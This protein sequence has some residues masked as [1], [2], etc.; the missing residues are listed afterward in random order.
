ME[1]PRRQADGWWRGAPR[2]LWYTLRRR[3]RILGLRRL[4]VHAGFSE[5]NAEIARDVPSECA[6]AARAVSLTARH[7]Q[8]V[9][10]ELILI[11]KSHGQPPGLGSLP[12]TVLT[13]AGQDATWMQ[14][15]AELA[16][17]S[18]AGTHIVAPRGGH[19]LQH[20]APGLVA[21]AIRDLMARIRAPAL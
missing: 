11:P 18:T 10:R 13:A 2:T 9:V 21:S 15:Q 8:A 20:D 5:L 16:G 6:A 3:A 1:R 4:A 12:L 19:D 7:R 17:L 14:M